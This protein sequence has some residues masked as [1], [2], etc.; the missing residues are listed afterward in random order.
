MKQTLPVKLAPTGDQAVALLATM[1]RFNL[2]CDAIGQV[3]FANRCANK[4]ELQKLVYYDTRER[5]GLSSQ[6]T[7][8]AISKVVEAYKRDKTIQPRFRPRGAVPYDQRIMSWK[9]V[10][11]VSLLTLGGR[12]LIPTRFGDYQAARLDRRQGQADLVLTDGTWFLY[13]TIDTP[14][15]TP[16]EPEDFLGVDLGIV[17]L[18]ADSDGTIYT[19][20]AI[21]TKRQVYSHRRRNLQ[22]NGSKS[23]TRKL[24]SIKGRQA[25][26][27]RDT[28]HR[29]SKTVVR[30]AKDTGRGIAVEDLTGIR[31]RITVRRQQRAR[32][33]NWSFAQLRAFLT[34]KAV[35]AGVVLV[36][37]DPRNTSR[38]CPECG[39]CDKRNRPNQACFRCQ[40]CGHAAPADTTAARCIRARAGVMRPMVSAA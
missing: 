38:T 9:G 25:R 40:S 26:Y 4:V 21:E 18:A 2:A 13:V 30:N 5:F 35:L 37:V 1:E 7:V 14:E 22:R 36:A 24:R 19:G 15:P 34:Y 3:A 12:E 28:N 23:A 10:E 8:R 32:H 33:G 17:N 27:Q 29:I 31:D 16:V 11:H 6:L 20:Q 39:H